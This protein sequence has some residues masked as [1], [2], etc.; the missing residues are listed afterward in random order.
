MGKRLRIVVS[1]LITLILSLSSYCQDRPNIVLIFP[2]NLGIGEV[3]CYG[4]VR[5]VPTPNIDRIAEEGIRL[6]NFNVEF[7]CVVSLVW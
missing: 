7:S 5:D 3:G 1:I 6:T 4:G 2:D